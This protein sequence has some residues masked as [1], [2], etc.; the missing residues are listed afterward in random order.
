MSRKWRWKGSRFARSFDQFIGLENYAGTLK[1]PRTLFLGESEIG[2]DW[3][4]SLF[5]FSYGAYIFTP[6][7]S[8]TPESSG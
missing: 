7:W 6:S 1:D 4:Q 2:L 5:M 8:N 3:H